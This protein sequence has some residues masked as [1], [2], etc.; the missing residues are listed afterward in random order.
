MT[1]PDPSDP[2]R[3]ALRSL[4]RRVIGFCVAAVVVIAAYVI[5]SRLGAFLPSR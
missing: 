4:I 1:T 3:I 2:S 5:A